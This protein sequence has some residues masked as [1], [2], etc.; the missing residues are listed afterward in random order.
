[1]DNA[2]F[3]EKLVKCEDGNDELKHY[4]I[5]DDPDIREVIR[6]LESKHIG[7]RIPLSETTPSNPSIIKWMR[8]LLS[9]SNSPN[10][11][12][13]E[14]LLN[15][16][17][18]ELSTRSKEKDKGVGLLVLKDL[19]FIAHFQSEPSLAKVKDR[20]Y[21]VKLLLNPK[22]I[23]RAVI[24]KVENG[25]H[26]LS[27]YEYNKKLTRGLADFLGIEPEDISWDTTG[28]ITLYFELDGFDLPLHIE[29]DSEQLD[30]LVKRRLIL[31]TGTIKTGNSIG[32]I[33][34]AQ[35][36]GKTMDFANFYDFYATHK[37]QLDE[38]K[39]KFSELVSHQLS[40]EHS[41]R[42]NENKYVY[43]EDDKKV[44][45]IT[46]SGTKVI[47]KKDNPRFVITY[48]TRQVPIIKPM[49]SLLLKISQAIF[50]NTPY[51]IWHAGELST[52]EP[53]QLGNLKVYNNLQISSGMLDFS[54][55][56]VNI[57]QDATS[58]K[59][60]ALFKL[61]YLETML[62]QM[63]N[64]HF[65]SIFSFIKDEHII[66]A[67]NQEF[68]S[69]VFNDKEDY[70]D[71]KSADAVSPK[72][73]KFAK[74]VLIPTVKK[75]FDGTRLSRYCIAYGIEDNG[76][77]KPLYNLKNDQI[78]EIENITNSELKEMPITVRL[79]NVPYKEGL[80]LLVFILPK[81]LR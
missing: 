57:I 38:H 55:S 30:D 5:K 49:N 27:A 40:L 41:Q 47:M 22:N 54:N 80:I 29:V 36:F 79:Q 76:Q 14:D 48:F 63:N 11:E 15:E 73:T 20:A 62:Q 56:I 34:K 9:A 28:S 10:P 26:I 35:V 31:P 60:N 46:P 58:K 66:P 8:A 72:P 75:Y 25:A 3:F 70:I 2:W 43:E 33:I 16:F 32:K 68:E 52:D 53:I 7:K 67:L 65:K 69:G 77:I 21:S 18:S 81:N 51:E 61:Y 74:E 78:T 6:N 45:E 59:S 13:A 42:Y 50:D 12:I 24:V 64:I 39:K 17:R 44:Y 37:E 71:F 23:Y 19:I 4:S 1:M